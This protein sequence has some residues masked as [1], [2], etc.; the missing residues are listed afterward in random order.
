MITR[1]TAKAPVWRKNFFQLTMRIMWKHEPWLLHHAI[2]KIQDGSQT[3]VQEVRQ[4][5]FY[6]MESLDDT[7]TGRYKAHKNHQRERNTNKLDSIKISLW[8]SK[9][10][11][12]I[13]QKL[14]TD[15]RWTS[16]RHRPI[17]TTYTQNMQRTA[18]DDLEEGIHF[19]GKRAKD[20]KRHFIQD[21]IQMVGKN[22]KTCS[23]SL[24]IKEMQGETKRQ[25][26]WFHQNGKNL[27]VWQH[28]KLAM[29]WS[30]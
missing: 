22:L 9:D 16:A 15:W 21:N 27:P 1:S 30:N 25:L 20:S 11:I 8:P 14:V 5:S 4:R 2:H 28:Q 18:T 10:T 12:D 6:K 3:S 17:Q 24:V 7:G 13:A 19:T 26:L 29:M 23:T